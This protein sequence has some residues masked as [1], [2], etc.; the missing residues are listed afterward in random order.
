M[1]PEIWRRYP[2]RHMSFYSFFDERV[3]RWRHGRTKAFLSKSDAMRRRKLG[4]YWNMIR[5]MKRLQPDKTFAELRT[6]ARKAKEAYA[7]LPPEEKWELHEEFV[8]EWV[9]P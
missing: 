2:H 6:E 1:E 8:Q 4:R 5:Q 3:N 7:R 9:S